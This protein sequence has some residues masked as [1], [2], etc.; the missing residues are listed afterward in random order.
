[1]RGS[2]ERHLA[3]FFFLFFEQV[4]IMH[5]NVQNL[6][7]S[8]CITLTPNTSTW[9]LFTVN[10]SSKLSSDILYQEVF[11]RAGTKH[12]IESADPFFRLVDPKLSDDREPQ[13]IEF[14]GTYC[15]AFCKMDIQYVVAQR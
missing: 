5:T 14:F 4:C 9:G 6:L 1:M 2:F 7:L 8:Q 11:L 15:M 13:K 3:F 12:Q 10:K